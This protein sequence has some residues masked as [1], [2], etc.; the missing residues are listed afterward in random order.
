MDSKLEDMSVKCI[1][2]MSKG[3]EL[4]FSVPHTNIEKSDNFRAVKIYV[5]KD[6]QSNPGIPTILQAGKKAK[7]I[8]LNDIVCFFTL[9]RNL[10][11]HIR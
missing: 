5:F 3:D 9:K 6:R 8:K 2:K 4:L 1:N 11:Y 7:E 10:L